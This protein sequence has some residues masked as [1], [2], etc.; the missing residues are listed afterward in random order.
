MLRRL[1]ASVEKQRPIKA[2]ARHQP[3]LFPL[4]RYDTRAA[5]EQEP[6][7]LRLSVGQVCR[8][9]CAIHVRQSSQDM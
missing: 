5:T 8:Q 3:H 9:G 1:V 2:S 4:I 7:P 6:A